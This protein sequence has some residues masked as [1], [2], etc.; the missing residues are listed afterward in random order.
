M[1]TIDKI[2][3]DSFKKA[4]ETCLLDIDADAVRHLNESVFRYYFIKALPAGI[5]KEDEWKRIDLLIHNESGHYPIEFK[6]YD[7]RPLNRFDSKKPS[8]KGG[9]SEKNFR[10]FK[11]SCFTLLDL[12]NNQ[13]I[14]KLGADIKDKYFILVAADRDSDK[15]KFADFYLGKHITKLQEEGVTSKEL[16]FEQK[17]IDSINVFGWVLKLDRIK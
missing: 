17:T 6:F 1:T 2:I 12:G 14:Q 11:K 9:P 5:G 13:E 10:E 16:V 15:V 4:F 7:K 3:S 8:Y